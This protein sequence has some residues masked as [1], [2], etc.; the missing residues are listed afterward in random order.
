MAHDDAPATRPASAF[1]AAS[2]RDWPVY[3]DHVAGAPPRETLLDA[4]ERLDR[5]GR[6]RFDS[7]HHHPNDRPLCVDLGCGDGRDTAEL[8]RRGWRTLAIDAHPD[9]FHR[10]LRRPDIP[11][12]PLLSMQRA[13]LEDAVLPP[14][15]L[16]NASYSLPFCR[17]EAFASLWARI[18]DA[19]RPGALFAGQLFGDRDTWASLP[20]RSHH[21]GDEVR[22]LLGPLEI[23]SLKEEERDAADAAGV[24]K[25]WH[26]FH[27]IARRPAPDARDPTP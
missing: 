2:D 17:P 23:L 9:A 19:L 24:Q 14:C 13:T 22:A 12:T 3:Y 20:D 6:G 7:T 5:L 11:P 10:M 4:L 16:V 8:V 21:T 1:G 15:D 25:H 18:L 27:V 26:L